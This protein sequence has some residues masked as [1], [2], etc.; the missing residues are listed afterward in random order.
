MLTRG[1]FRVVASANN[2]NNHFHHARGLCGSAVAT[3]GDKN[4]PRV[5]HNHPFLLIK[6][7]P[8]PSGYYYLIGTPYNLPAIE[9]RD[10]FDNS[11]QR[12]VPYVSFIYQAPFWMG[13]DLTYVYM[14]TD[15]CDRTWMGF[16]AR[17]I[18]DRNR[19]LNTLN[20]TRVAGYQI[21]LV[22][23]P[24]PSF[25]NVINVYHSDDNW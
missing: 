20:K 1:T 6:N 23:S 12:Y 5:K 14:W 24:T 16:C 11:F 18:W 22:C 15:T 3:R 13:T 25:Y 21:T 4:T 17:K 10:A 7:R 9:T 8:L 19:R 2:T